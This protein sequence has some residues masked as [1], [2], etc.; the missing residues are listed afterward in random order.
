LPEASNPVALDYHV[1]PKPLE[2]IF[3]AKPLVSTLALE[4]DA[5]AR[6]LL[7]KI[8]L[9]PQSHSDILESSVVQVL[10]DRDGMV[11]SA[12]LLESSGSRKADQD[13][14][15]LASKARFAPS[16]TDFDGPSAPI[17]FGKLIFNWIALTSPSTR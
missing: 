3:P 9:P 7:E 17:S 13:A 12:R 11:V 16:I 1:T 14:V 10:I 8:D 6:G 4:G 2:I 5:Q 15:A